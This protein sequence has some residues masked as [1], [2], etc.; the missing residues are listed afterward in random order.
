MLFL[1]P[2][3]R[4]C[5]VYTAPIRRDGINKIVTHIKAHGSPTMTKHHPTDEKQWV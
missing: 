3:L 1:P 4:V 5:S 2:A